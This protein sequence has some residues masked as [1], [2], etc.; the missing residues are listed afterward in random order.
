MDSPD[1]EEEVRFVDYFAVCGLDPRDGVEPNELTVDS[2]ENLHP[3][4]RGYKSKVLAHYPE[5]LAWNPFDH[6]G[7][8]MLCMPKGLTF[9]TQHQDRKPKFHSFVVTREDRTQVYGAALTFYE[10]VT[11]EKLCAQFNLLQGKFSEESNLRKVSTGDIPSGVVL[12]S[13]SPRMGRRYTSRNRR[14]SSPS[15]QG[16]N[17]PRFR[18]RGSPAHQAWNMQKANT[19]PRTKCSVVR[20]YDIMKDALFVSKCI[21]VVMKVPLVRSC[22]QFLEQLYEIIRTR[23]PESLPIESYVYNILYEV[24]LPPPGKSMEFFG[25]VRRISCQRPSLWELPLCEY[26]M[27]EMFELLGPENVLELLTCAFLEKQILFLSKDYQRLML[28]AECL[29]ALLFPFR[30]Q[31][32]YVPIVPASMLHFLDAP[33]SF[34]MGLHVEELLEDDF[35]VPNQASMCYVDIDTQTAEYPEDLPLLPQREYLLHEMKELMH[36]FGVQI[37]DMDSNSNTLPNPV[38]NIYDFGK[39]RHEQTLVGSPGRGY[40]LEG[41]LEG[42]QDSSYS[43]SPSGGESPIPML[44]SKVEFLQNNEVVSKVAAIAQRTGVISSI[45]DIQVGPREDDTISPE[46]KQ[47]KEY[48]NDLVFNCAIR[49]TILAHLVSLLKHYERFVIH[50]K[51]PNLESWFT[52]REHMHNY[53]KASFLSDQPEAYLPF[54]SSFLESQMFATF[55]DNKIISGFEEKDQALE[56]FDQRIRECPSSAPQTPT[57]GGSLYVSEAEA[58][59]HRRARNVSYAPPEP[60][61]LPLLTPRTCHIPGF[62]PKLDATLLEK[63]P[64]NNGTRDC[65][66]NQWKHNDKWPQHEEH[67]RVAREERM[68]QQARSPSVKTSVLSNYDVNQATMNFVEELLKECKVKTKKMLVFKM[69]QEAVELGHGDV[70]R[71]GVEENTLIA[72]LCDFLERIFSHRI[73][74]KQSANFQG[75][76]ALWSFLVAYR[77]FRTKKQS[78]SEQN[79]YSMER[80]VHTTHRRSSVVSDQLLQPLPSD[81]MYD[82]RNVEGMSEIKTDVG[83][84]RAFVRLSLERKLLH[85]HLRELVSTQELCKRRYKRYAFLRAEEEKEQFLYY[86]LSLNAVDHTCFTNSFISTVIAY[87]VM[88]IQSRK[89]QAPLTANPWICVSGEI[90][91][92]KLIPIPKNNQGFLFQHQNL[93]MLTTV[94]IGHDNAGFLPRW[95][96]DYVVIRNEITGHTYKFPCGKWIGKGVDDGSL[97]RLLVGELLPLSQEVEH[98][99]GRGSQT[100]PNRKKSATLPRPSQTSIKLD[101][102]AI[103]EKLTDAVNNIVKHFYKPDKERG[104]FTPL[105]CGE[106]GLVHCMEMVLQY[107]F[108]SSRLFQKNFYI[109]DFLEKVKQCLDS[110]DEKEEGRLSSQQE[111]KAR[112]TFCFTLEQI[113]QHGKTM[114]KDGKFQMLVCIGI[115]NHLFYQWLPILAE[116]SVAKNM[117]ED[118]SFFNNPTALDSIVN[119]LMQLEEFDIVLESSIT[120]GVEI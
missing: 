107:G 15:I 34:I 36:V 61:E 62:F 27:R 102:S 14:S 114:G 77:R 8:N 43:S 94:R 116:T 70:N 33:F 78:S 47:K 80:P 75:K 71:L 81:I 97:E 118:Y 38:R 44:P 16:L 67:L 12:E 63:E 9:C 45:S 115:R 89:F 86:L 101:Q 52:N 99:F 64:F 103:Q 2:T 24:P 79:L 88:I 51:E 30:W 21:C 35:E 76:S 39:G 19:L 1:S 87:R 68:I 31:H 56:I 108:R 91:T 13:V 98:D 72:S 69:G 28:V 23:D 85:N 46:L 95:L 57:D 32:V 120:K 3:L 60:H 59:I 40:S 22:Q 20:H 5:Q 111:K 4:H 42:D 6:V 105:L 53:D 17:S 26:A 7:I 119:L 55:I 100:L 50:P 37:T 106:D 90:N 54:L 104:P 66:A 93:G 65:R 117:Y 110:L 10:L 25:P 49:E 48:V 82:M 11:D 112:K 73:H 84:A 96:V 113:T 29:T 58:M 18:K 92:T 74:R 109:W 83:R 41:S